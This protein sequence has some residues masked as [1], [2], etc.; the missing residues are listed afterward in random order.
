VSTVGQDASIWVDIIC[1]MVHN[2]SMSIV[3]VKA[4]HCDRCGYEWLKVGAAPIR[5]ANPDKRC[6][7]WNRGAEAPK[8]VPPVAPV[9]HKTSTAPRMSPSMDALRAICA[10]G[11]AVQET[12]AEPVEMCRHTEYNQQTGETYGCSRMA[13]HKGPCRKVVVS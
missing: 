3:T 5:C 11:V 2:V 10:G 1:P 4:W 12:V 9:A 13:G 8:P 7:R 6:R